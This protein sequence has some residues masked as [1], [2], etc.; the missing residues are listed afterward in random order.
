MIEAADGRVLVMP[1]NLSVTS[2][3]VGLKQGDEDASRAL[4]HRYFAQL[5]RLARQRLGQSPRR[6]ADEEDVAVSVFKSLCEGAERGDFESLNDR[7]DLWRLLATITVRKAGQ[8]IRRFTRQKRGG[9]Q[10]RG[11]SVFAAA[12][13]EEHNEG[14]DGLPS[15][16]PTPEFLCQM[17]EEHQRLLDRLEEPALRQIATWKMEGYS[18]QEIATRLGITTRSVERKAQRIRE[19]WRSELNP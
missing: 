12:D 4:W 2:W 11:D 18:T 15:P 8:Q 3:I 9:G 5:V 16:E 14:F 19:C 13:G 7:E 6:V 10:V 1:D 17:A